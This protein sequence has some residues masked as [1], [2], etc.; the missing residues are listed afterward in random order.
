MNSYPATSSVTVTET[1]MAPFLLKADP[2]QLRDTYTVLHSTNSRLLKSGMG[3]LF[4]PSGVFQPSETFVKINKL[5]AQLGCVMKPSLLVELKVECVVIECVESIFKA[6]VS[7]FGRVFTITCD[8]KQVKVHVMSSLSECEGFLDC[9]WNKSDNGAG[10]VTDGSSW[11]FYV[12]SDSEFA[13]SNVYT[14]SV[15]RSL[16][17][18]LRSFLVYNL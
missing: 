11:I 2:S 14:Y 12:K 8:E 13:V 17:F 18:A 3:H 7:E 10:V 6:K 16:L 5:N 1:L 15:V 9:V 4:L